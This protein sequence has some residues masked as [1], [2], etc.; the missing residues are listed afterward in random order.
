M[1]IS[2][3][4]NLSIRILGVLLVTAAT[5]F[6]AAGAGRT[7]QGS[8]LTLADEN[9]APAGWPK[10]PDGVADKFATVFGLKIH[11]QEAG[12][13]P[14]VILLHGLGGDASNWASTIGPLSKKY[15]VIVPDQVGFGRSDKPL[16]NY[17]VGTLVDFLDAFMKELKID[18][19]SVVGNSLGGWT[20]AAFALA[21]PEK[22]DKLVL[23]DAAG[24]SLDKNVDPKTLN[25]L[26]PSTRA[27]VLQVISVV[28]YNKQMFAN[29]A[30]VD[31]FFAR[32]LATGDG[33]TIQRFIDSIVNGQD[34]L[35]STAGKIKQPTLVV[36]GQQDLLVPLAIGERYHKEIAGSQMLVIDKCGHVPMVEQAERFNTALIGFLDTGA[37]GG[38]ASAVR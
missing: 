6:T 1:E 18:R 16:I 12:T 7:G 5:L 25:I 28:F 13:G 21:H 35:D 34:V 4:R 32:K 37:V 2:F 29:P 33:Y 8:S 3:R 10:P 9:A 19:A 22:V 23:V 31:A 24:F 14:A 15:H 11:Y 26:N 20:A 27:D 17:G 30:A 38:S 36:W